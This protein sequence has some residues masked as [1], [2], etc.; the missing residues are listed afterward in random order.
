MREGQRP[1]EHGVDDAVNVVVAPIASP[2]SGCD[3]REA[4]CQRELARGVAE[5][6]EDGVHNGAPNEIFMPLM[7]WLGAPETPATTTACVFGV[8]RQDA[9]SDSGQSPRLSARAYRLE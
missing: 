2:R 3:D 5:I 8:R 1:D 4:G 9:M 7:V 6:T